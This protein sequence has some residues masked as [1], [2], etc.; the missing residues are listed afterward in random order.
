MRAFSRKGRARPGCLRQELVGSPWVRGPGPRGTLH[1]ASST[2][3][4]LQ[5]PS[6]S[7]PQTWSVVLLGCGLPGHRGGVL[8]PPG[9]C[10]GWLQG[11]GLLQKERGSRQV[12]VEGN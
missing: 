9:A 12:G 8:A 3:A 10:C 7:C 11:W 1:A 2:G 6:W 4:G 5:A